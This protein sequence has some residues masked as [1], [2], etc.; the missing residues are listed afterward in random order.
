M[1]GQCK[2]KQG[3]ISNNFTALYFQVIVYDTNYY[4]MIKTLVAVHFAS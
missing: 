1:L 3:H 4:E 2:L